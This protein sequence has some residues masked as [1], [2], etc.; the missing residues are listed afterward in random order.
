[1]DIREN[2]AKAYNIPIYDVI[3]TNICK[4]SI[5]IDFVIQG[6]SALTEKNHKDK[7]DIARKSLKDNMKLKDVDF[8]M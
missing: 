5:N 8:T 1:M 4:G 3:I 7:I 6:F 2:I